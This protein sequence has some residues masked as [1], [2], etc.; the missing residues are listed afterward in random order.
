MVQSEPSPEIKQKEFHIAPML[1]VST[2]EFCHFFRILSKRAI[3]WTGMLVDSTIN[4]TKRL[5]HQLPYSPE[6]SPIICQIG[7]RDATSCGQATK[8]VE[9]YGYDEINLN[10]DHTKPDIAPEHLYYNLELRTND[11]HQD[12]Q[13]VQLE[14]LNA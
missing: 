6:L 3:L 4:H 8:V 11:S 12:K 9:A 7:G 2:Q 14:Y 5:D 13:S 1:D 10:I